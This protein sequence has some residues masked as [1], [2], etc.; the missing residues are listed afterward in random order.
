MIKY[1]LNTIL[2]FNYIMARRVKIKKVKSKL[3]KGEDINSM[4]EEMMGTKDADPTIIIP[5]YISIKDDIRKIYKILNQF[6]NFK[7]LQ[8]DFPFMETPMKEIK[9]FCD[10]LE[11]DI[12]THTGVNDNETEDLYS[13]ISKKEINVMYNKL[14]DSDYV[15][16]LTI[17]CSTLNRHRKDLDLENL[18]DN[19]I[20]IEPGTSFKVFKFSSFDLKSLWYD[21]HFTPLVNKYVLTILSKILTITHRIYE[22]ITSPN[23]DIEKFTVLIINSLKDLKKRPELS[24]CKNAFKK[25]EDAVDLLSNNFDKYYRQSM[26]S[27]NSTIILEN[28]IL[29]V[30]KTESE[31]D[32]SLTREFR[33]IVQYLHKMSKKSGKSSD[34]NIQKLFGMMNNNF[35]LLDKQK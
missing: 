4:F 18:S 16:Q 33:V 35:D 9:E 30:S 34:P 24:R 29:D 31:S 20:L 25:I 14:R 21:K 19:F 26:E 15:K 3:P 2:F 11:K 10:G 12:F 23:I 28:F 1:N 32:A 7:P 6:S 8:N 17:L 5:K 22:S 13:K 27:G